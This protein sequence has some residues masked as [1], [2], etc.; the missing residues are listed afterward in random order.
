MR[1]ALG[2]LAMEDGQTEDIGW[3]AEAEA[4][5]CAFE[6]G[7]PDAGARLAALPPAPNGGE[8]RKRDIGL[9]A[10]TSL[11]NAGKYAPARDLVYALR[12]DEAEFVTGSD[13][14]TD[15]E[16]DAL[17]CLAMLDLEAAPDGRPLG[18]PD[19][20]RSRLRRV[21][22]VI[23]GGGTLWWAALRGLAQAM[24]ML[25]DT[26][27]VVTLAERTW[28][29][30]PGPEAAAWALTT[31]ANAGRYDAARA[32][33]KGSGLDTAS[34]SQPGITRSMTDAERDAVFSL[35][36]L[37]VQTD[38]RRAL[39]EPAM[40]R[41]RF[42]RVRAAC[43]PGSGLWIAALRGELQALDMLDAIDEAAALTGDVEAAFPGVQL[44]PD[45]LAR[46]GKA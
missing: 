17:F 20:A 14:L 12:L 25:G 42:A 16:R 35:A 1:R 44:P 4:I 8:R 37:D 28:R 36:V 18:S 34:F 5:L 40:A 41:G 27:G 46:V 15:G 24:R 30:Q 10:M 29:D 19:L 9:R 26:E 21:L 45:I 39:G 2:E 6:A 23:P 11:V 32:V 33:A 22:D 7:S 31:L 3:T 38:G 13:R 43:P